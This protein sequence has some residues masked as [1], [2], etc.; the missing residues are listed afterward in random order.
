MVDIAGVYANGIGVQADPAKAATWFKKA[1]DLGNAAAMTGLGSLY[2]E[3]KG[4]GTDV[5]KAVTLY[6][7]A[8]DLGNSIAMTQLAYLHVQGKGVEQSEPAAV[9]YYKKAVALGNAIAMNNLAWMLQGG[10]GVSRKDPQEA[11]NL[12]MQALDRRYE[13]SH[14]QMTQK[15]STWSKEFRQALQTRLRDAGFFTGRVD[16]EF[17]ASTIA[18][19]NAYIN[20]PR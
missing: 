9:A 4:V 6:R 14:M 13:F 2:L 5:A 19:I 1:A 10:R 15:S 16:G 17:G 8:A 7:Q 20:R 12:M 11:A 3:G 18:A